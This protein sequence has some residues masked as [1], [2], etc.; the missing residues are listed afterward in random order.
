MTNCLHFK[1]LLL[2]LAAIVLTTPTGTINN[3]QL[4]SYNVN[5]VANYT[6]NVI[7]NNATNRASVDLTFP[8]QCVLSA[9]TAAYIGA[10]PLSYSYNA[11]VLTVNSSLLSGTVSIIVRNVKN[12]NSAITTSAFSAISS[13]DPQFSYGSI[14]SYTTGLLQSSTWSFSLC[15]E[16]PSSVLTI[17]VMTTNVIPSGNS[18]FEVGYGAWANHYNKNLLTGVTTLNA[19]VSINGGVNTS[20]SNI[21]YDTNS[22]KITINYTLSGELPGSS[23]LTFI[24]SGVQSP[25]TQTTPANSSFRVATADGL[26]TR[27][28]EKTSVTILPTCVLNITTGIFGYTAMEVNSNY[29]SSLRI[30]YAET[31]II[32]FQA[33][34]TFEVHYNYLSSLSGCTRFDFWRN[35]SKDTILSTMN[36]STSSYYQYVPTS[37]NY[38]TDYSLNITLNLICSSIMIPPSETP[39]VLTFKF[40]RNGAQYL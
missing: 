5:A 30:L 32:T 26:G 36:Q 6:W 23:N 39:V 20:V 33:T 19:Q 14:V 27:I 18:V 7:F 2:L 11:N 28:D 10:T 12:P 9:S 4:D 15:T 37:S 35:N 1:R 34:D 29:P 31:P 3:I 21:A 13:I 24:I 25:P 38:N 40:K 16:Q 8:T 17:N 22:Q